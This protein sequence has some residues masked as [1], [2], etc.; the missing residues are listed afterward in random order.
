MHVLVLD[1]VG[2]SL[3]WILPERLQAKVECKLALTLSP[4]LISLYRRLTPAYALEGWGWFQPEKRLKIKWHK[5]LISWC[6]RSQVHLWCASFWILTFWWKVSTRA[7]LDPSLCMWLA[8]PIQGQ[9]RF[10]FPRKFYLQSVFG[11]S[12]LIKVH[13]LALSK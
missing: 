5:V 8:P 7:K 13:D 6:T 11:V 4:F 3:A 9:I 10:W 1:T 12:S 2:Q